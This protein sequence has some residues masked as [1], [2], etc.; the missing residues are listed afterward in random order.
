MNTY[1]LSDL[2]NQYDPDHDTTPEIPLVTY[3]D[4]II[5]ETLMRLVEKVT[6]L[7]KRI[8]ELEQ[9]QPAPSN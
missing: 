2:L 3:A 7:E 1:K 8:Q 5:A 4:N 9:Q 6:R